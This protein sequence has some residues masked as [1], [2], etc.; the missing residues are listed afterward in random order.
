MDP[1]YDWNL[2]VLGPY[3]LVKFINL[4]SNWLFNCQIDYFNKLDWNEIT[5]NRKLIFRSMIIEI[6]MNEFSLYHKQSIR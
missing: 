2:V 1:P 6:I 4:L 5:E 3:R